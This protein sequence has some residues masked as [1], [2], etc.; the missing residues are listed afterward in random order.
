MSVPA[1]FPA[2]DPHNTM[3][4]SDADRDRVAE[5]LREAY[6][7]GRLDV[8]EHN[9]RLDRTYQ[10][11]TLGELTP[12][13]SDLPQR[14]THTAS[15][16][17]GPGNPIPAMPADYAPGS[18][19]TAVFAEQKRGGRWLVPSQT[20]AAAIFGQ[21]TIDLREAVLTQRE[22]V[23]VANAV[24]GSIEIK[25]PHGVVVRDE[26]TAVFGSRSGSDRNAAGDVPI[27]PDSPVVVLRGI[28]LFGEVSVRYPKPKKLG[29]FL[30]R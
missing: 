21:V 30:G 20:T 13:L 19:V 26:G 27:T 24:F 17:P 4:A 18:S 3:R 25:V 2:N 29:K 22:V 23:I 7:E 15:P 9:E 6:A 28:A 10:A 14:H 16:V 11:K 8:E 5:A 12:L 1:A